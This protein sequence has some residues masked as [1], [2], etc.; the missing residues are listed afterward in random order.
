M[1]GHGDSRDAVLRDF[2][3]W[4]EQNDPGGAWFLD[5]GPTAAPPAEA[6]AEAEA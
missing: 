6:E 1:S 4:L 5:E 3:T 2:L